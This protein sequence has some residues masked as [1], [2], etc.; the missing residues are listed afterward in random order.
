MI[1]GFEGSAEQVAQRREA[2]TALLTSLGGTPGGEEP[3]RA[4]EHGRFR[5]PYLRDSMLDLGVLVETLET[6]TFW[7][8][9]E[10][11]YAAVKAALEGELGSD[12]SP[13]LVLC[14]VSHVY[15]TGCSLYFTVA[16][17]LGEEPLEQWLRAKRAASDAIVAQ[18]ATISHHHAV[19]TDH[20]ARGSRARSARSAYGSCGRSRPSSTRRE[21]S[22]PAC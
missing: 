9:V 5:A 6:A 12:G 11:L 8:R 19:G 22:T 7:S 2:V 17:R 20:R 16:A 15:E 14:H 1:V 3:G 21:C 18:G 4:W 13:A 10:D